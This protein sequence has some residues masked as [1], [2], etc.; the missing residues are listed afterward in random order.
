[1]KMEK[2]A[3]Y[4]GACLLASVV[5]TSANAGFTTVSDTFS[6]VLLVDNS[7]SSTSLN[8]TDTGAITDL[9]VWVDFTKC[10][11][12]LLDDGTCSGQGFSFNREIVFSLTSAL[13]TMVNLVAQDTYSGSAP[14]ARVEVLFD[15]AAATAVG[16]STLT[17]G[18]FSPAGLLAD[19]NGE[20]L[21]G[22]WTLSFQDTVGSDPLSLNAWRLDITTDSVSVP[23]PASLA[24]LG[25]G[26]VG[27]G[28]S[29]K[30]KP[31]RDVI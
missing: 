5:A 11:N 16:G 10:D 30:R 12:P 27:F 21:F 2:N 28:L 14:G 23:E 25:L 13:G 24:L 8:I 9:N 3:Y 18:S 19:F 31:S 17:S 6:P 29:R 4:M 22:N 7:S 26:L 1:M 20:D 15:D